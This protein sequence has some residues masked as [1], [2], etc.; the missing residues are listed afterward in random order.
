M[1]FF[2]VFL[3]FCGCLSSWIVMVVSSHAHAYACGGTPLCFLH[4]VYT[5][6]MQRC[7]PYVYRGVHLIHYR[8][9]CFFKDMPV[10]LHKQDRAASERPL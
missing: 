4:K 1:Y 5:L 9:I 3:Y 7:T 8:H 10:F 6:Y 2:P